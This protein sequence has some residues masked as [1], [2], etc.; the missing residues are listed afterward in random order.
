MLNKIKTSYQTFNLKYVPKSV[1]STVSI[2]KYNDYL[3]K[4]IGQQVGYNNVYA[5]VREQMP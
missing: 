5:S 2:C 4:R 1:I 3:F